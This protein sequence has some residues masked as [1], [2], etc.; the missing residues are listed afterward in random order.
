MIKNFEHFPTEKKLH[1]DMLESKYGPIH[2]E[3][4][5]H[6]ELLREAHLKDKKNISRTYA[7]TFFS[8]DKNNNEI[9][10]IDNQI[11]DGGM[12]GATFR[13]YGYT[14]RKN[15]IDVF[16]FN[17]PNWLKHDFQVK[18]NVAKTRLSEFYAKKDN[19]APFIYGTVFEVYSPDFREPSINEIDIAQINPVTKKFENESVSIEKIWTKLGQ[20]AEINEWSDIQ[21]KFN[22]AMVES[23]PFIKKFH[24]RIRDYFELKEKEIFL[25]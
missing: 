3:I 1:T 9:K 22:K 8:F 6:N 7:L 12:I 25:K 18:D 2:S 23:K 15:V 5:K 10:E 20:A 19:G 16:I 4:L 17:I 13:K 14:V 21:E 24:K 11:K